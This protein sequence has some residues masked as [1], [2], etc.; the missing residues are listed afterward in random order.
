MS[1]RALVVTLVSIAIGVALACKASQ[2]VTGGGLTLTAA[3]GQFKFGP[4]TVTVPANAVSSTVQVSIG[5]SSGTPSSPRMVGTPLNVTLSPTTTLAAPA[6]IDVDYSGFTLPARIPGATLQL[7][8]AQ[9]GVWVALSGGTNNSN[10]SIIS[11]PV[12]HFSDFALLGRRAEGIQALSSMTQSAQVS[13]AVAS[14][15]SVKVTDSIGAALQGVTVAFAVTGGGGSISPATKVTDA[16]GTATATSWT[17]GPSAGANTATATLADLPAV[18]FTANATGGGGNT[19]SLDWFADWRHGTGD[20]LTNT[21]DG[22]PGKFND[23]CCSTAPP[24]LFNIIAASGLG[25]PAAMQNVARIDGDIVDGRKMDAFADET[26]AQG[27][28]QPAVGQYQ[29]FRWYFRNSVGTGIEGGGA[30]V[31]ES[32]VGYIAWA[33]K[34]LDMLST[35]KYPV[36]LFLNRTNSY[37]DFWVSSTNF[38]K[39]VVYRWEL[40]LYR[41]DATH[42]QAAVRVYGPDD[43]TLLFTEAN[44]IN[45][46]DMVSVLGTVLPSMPINNI[47]QDLQSIDV[48]QPNQAGSIWTAGNYM[49]VGA[50]AMRMSSSSTAWIG[51]YPVVGAEAAPPVPGAPLPTHR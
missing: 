39:D 37:T 41:V 7:Y 30:H 2:T 35:G 5:N 8:T 46:A 3:G 50:M 16:T 4:F 22:S 25:F 34:P 20:S 29:F 14:P 36:S 42:F 27:G 21:Q 47:Q 44:F 18:T 11:T 43:T 38:S 10:T 12:S 9:G 19:G 33:F 49:Y 6:T 13:S 48:G 51:K 17:T 1:K 26:P 28:A 24:S 32:H 40:R 23:Y 15:P 45:A 31:I